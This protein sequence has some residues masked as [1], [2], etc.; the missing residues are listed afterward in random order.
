MTSGLAVTLHVRDEGSPSRVTPTLV[1]ELFPK[2]SVTLG[3]S[4]KNQRNIKTI[5]EGIVE[6][7]KAVEDKSHKKLQK[8]KLLWIHFQTKR[9]F[10]AS[11]LFSYS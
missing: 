8:Q 7:L 2:E 6:G 11:G 4:V 1:K 9:T 3:S 5:V 10:F